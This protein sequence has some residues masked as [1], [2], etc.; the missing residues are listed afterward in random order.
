LWG[1]EDSLQ[2]K[3]VMFVTKYPFNGS[4]PLPNNLQQ[5]LY[6]SVLPSFT[7]Y[8]TSISITATVEQLA[9]DSIAANVEI[10]N[11]RSTPLL[12]EK[13]L[14]GEPTALIISFEQGRNIIQTF[15]LENL[16]AESI[17]PHG[18]IKKRLR[19]SIKGLEPRSY[20]TFIGIR[21]GV[22]P[23]AILSNE[24]QIDIKR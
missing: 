19:I 14:N 6:Y 21:N 1:Y 3:E 15:V 9:V 10:I 11:H 8:Y 24:M 2:G 13:G 20:S 5:N 7:S 16:A 18:S 4:K 22:L 23:D 17:D 12:F